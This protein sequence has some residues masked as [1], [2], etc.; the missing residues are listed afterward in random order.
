MKREGKSGV[1]SSRRE[2]QSNTC[3]ELLFG[4]WHTFT[5]TGIFS[6]FFFFLLLVSFCSKHYIPLNNSCFALTNPDVRIA[7]DLWAWRA[8]VWGCAW[9]TSP[10]HASH[11]SWGSTAW[12]APPAPTKL[13]LG[14]I[15]YVCQP[16]RYFAVA[17]SKNGSF[18]AARCN[19]WW[20]TGSSRVWLQQ[21]ESDCLFGRL[22]QN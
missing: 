22:V 3:N 4:I 16:V 2:K 19:A 9:W 5:C 10:S 13:L 1:E 17:L 18:L 8:Y 12:P 6:G 11:C 21:A 14:F 20:W 7:V 15:Y